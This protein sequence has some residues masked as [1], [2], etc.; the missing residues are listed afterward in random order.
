MRGPFAALTMGVVLAAAACGGSSDQS[1]PDTATPSAPAAAAV[2][3][4]GQKSS[5]AQ[6]ARI[7]F[8]ATFTGATTGTMTGEGAFAKRQ[9][10]LTLDMSG[11]AGGSAI[12]AGKAE[13]VFDKLVY[14]MK[15]PPGSGV[16]LPPGKDWFK[17]DL[18][19]LSQSKGLNL[20]QLTQLNQSDPSQALDFMRGASDDFHEVGKETVR[21]DE[22]T[23]FAGTIDL[24]RVAANAPP[25]VAE[26]YRKLAQLSPSKKV[27]MD[28]WVGHDGLVRRL[29]FTQ[30]LAGD[31]KMTMDEEIYDYGTNADV[32]PPPA[33]QVVDLTDFIAQS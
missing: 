23:H 10:R 18:A 31:S 14:Y 1:A 4:A 22:T 6:S 19:K 27:P 17:I 3:L 2:V 16:P 21:G 24:D 33:D 26:Q 15:L 8:T 9:G 13:L 30:S 7:S 12:P 20:E 11:L 25:D 29:S 28:V 32:T 5:D